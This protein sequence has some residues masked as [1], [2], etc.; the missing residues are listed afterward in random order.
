M[1]ETGSILWMCKIITL[2]SVLLLFNGVV[3]GA[4]PEEA[5]YSH[6]TARYQFDASSPQFIQSAKTLDKDCIPLMIEIMNTESMQNKWIKKVSPIKPFY[7]HLSSD[8]VAN[9]MLYR[10][11]LAFPYIS[12]D[13]TVVDAV[14]QF[15][16]HSMQTNQSLW[17]AD[18]GAQSMS[19]M[20]TDYSH[21]KLKQLHSDVTNGKYNFEFVKR[22]NDKVT[23]AIEKYPEYL[24]RFL[25]NQEKRRKGEL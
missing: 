12:Q 16:V 4:S 3:L 8:I 25:D 18:I 5:V 14:Y 13:T 2:I 9:H 17:C 22:T 1:K 21:D 11:V 24:Q 15:T 7:Y 20:T 23:K 10:I 19:M 6:L